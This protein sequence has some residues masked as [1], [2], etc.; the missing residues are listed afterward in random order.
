MHLNDY[1]ISPQKNVNKIKTNKVNANNVS[2]KNNDRG[3]LLDIDF[4][5]LPQETRIVSSFNAGNFY[6]EENNFVKENSFGIGGTNMNKREHLKPIKQE[7]EVRNDYSN[8]EK[9]LNSLAR[10]DITGIL[11]SINFDKEDS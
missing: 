10:V 11:E 1:S 4:T 9:S 3:M 6:N 8:I 5:L 7:S 2:E